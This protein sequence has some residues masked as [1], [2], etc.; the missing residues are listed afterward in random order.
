MRHLF[1]QCGG[2]NA[3]NVIGLEDRGRELHGTK[4]SRK[5]KTGGIV[6]GRAFVS[7]KRSTLVIKEP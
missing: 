7:K 4:L 1:V 3:A 5:I 6:G 2:H